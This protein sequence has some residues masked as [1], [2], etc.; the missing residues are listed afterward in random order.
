MSV[1]SGAR[2]P[3]FRF[4]VCCLLALML[5]KSLYLTFL[6]PSFLMCKIQG[7]NNTCLIGL[8]WA[9]NKLGCANPLEQGLR[10]E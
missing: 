6:C 9:L 3:G 10:H 4:Q 5:D 7:N 1:G 8:S 2:I